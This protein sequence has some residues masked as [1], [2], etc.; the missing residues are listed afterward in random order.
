M[1][2]RD[3]AR[4]GRRL[5]AWRARRHGLGERVTA[6]GPRL[7][8]LTIVSASAVLLGMSACADGGGGSANDENVP[9]PQAGG[10]P[11]L[12]SFD[13][14]TFFQP[15]QLAS[16]GFPAE[17]R[18]DDTLSFEPGCVWDG[19]KALLTL[20][21]NTEETVESYETSGSWDS[22]DK[23]TIDGRPAAVALEPGATGLGSCTVLVDAGGGVAIYMLD[24]IRQDSL[25]DPCGETKKIASESAAELPK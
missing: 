24:G 17:G 19:E 14:C 22:Y 13:P 8:A 2:V 10:G 20:L 11:A 4:R 25:P 3:T 7:R 16:W 9:N 15:E 23:T 18:K 21:K 5:A 6:T 1:R 12:E